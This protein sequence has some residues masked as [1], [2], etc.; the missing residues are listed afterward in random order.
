[1]TSANNEIK[2]I[3]LKKFYKKRNYCRAQLH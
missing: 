3:P 2:E 1:M